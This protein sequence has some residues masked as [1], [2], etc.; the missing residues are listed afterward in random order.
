MK[1]QQGDCVFRSIS[2]I[3]EGARKVEKQNG[4]Y[5]LRMGEATGHAHAVEQDMELYE[6]DGVLYLRGS[7][8]IE[9]THEEHKT[10]I[11]EPNVIWRMTPKIEYD[12]EAEEIRQVR[13]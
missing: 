10:E 2:G 6:K 7:S 3:P 9:V 5:I 12:P 11:L 8:P 1:R 13:D 4:R